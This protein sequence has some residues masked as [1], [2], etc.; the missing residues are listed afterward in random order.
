MHDINNWNIV[1]NVQHSSIYL[2][3]LTTN[4]QIP[5]LQSL[6][7]KKKNPLNVILDYFQ[8]QTVQNNFLLNGHW[9]KV[10]STIRLKTC[11]RCL[12]EIIAIQE[13]N[14]LG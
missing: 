6:K 14:I 3:E 13:S 1:F 12:T 7:G 5:T 11:E 2:R 10:S 9:T 4:E 8:R